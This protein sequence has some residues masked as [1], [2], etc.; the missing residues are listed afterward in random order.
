[1]WKYVKKYLFFAILAVL[2]M[3]G[4]VCMD[5]LQPALMSKIIDEGVLGTHN[6]G[7]TDLQYIWR[8]GLI[9]FGLVTLG[10]FFGAL[11]NVFV[12]MT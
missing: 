5:L 3:V 8:L 4:E 7:V 10:A 2:F 6:H 11:N 9:M 1:M 12:H